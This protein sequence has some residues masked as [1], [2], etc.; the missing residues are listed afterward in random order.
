M[1]MRGLVT[2]RE[3]GLSVPRDVS[4]MVWDDSP[5]CRLAY[6]PLTALRRDAFQYGRLVASH[7]LTRLSGQPVTDRRGTVA[8]IQVRDSTGPA[9][10][11]A[12]LPVRR[13]ES[14]RIR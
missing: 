7:L 12:V 1:A 14:A 3:L 6:P 9:P 11:P 13:D 2:M 8:E 10:A 5:L 4:V